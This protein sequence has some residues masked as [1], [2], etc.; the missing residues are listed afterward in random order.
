[1]V[2]KKS[3]F[4][5]YPER[6]GAINGVH[7]VRPQ[8]VA[9]VEFSNWTGDGRLRHPSFQG[10]RE[11]KAATEVTR[12]IAQATP[13]A[14]SKTTSRGSHSAKATA[15]AAATNSSGKVLIKGVELT[16]PDRVFYPD[17]GIT[18]RELAEYYV[19]CAER[20]L[21]HVAGRPLSIVRCPDGIGG[22]RFFQKHLGPYAPKAVRRVQIREKSGEGE[23]GVV[24]DT[25]GLVALAQI[26]ALEIHVWGSR[27]D[28]VER[29]DRLVFDLDPAPDVEWPRVIAA[30]QELR[31]FLRELKLESFVKTTGGKGLHLVVPIIR[32]Q[33][34]GPVYDFCRRIAV[35]VERAAPQRYI[36]TMSKKARTGKIFIDYQR[37]QRGATA[38]AA[39]S[40]RA[41]PG[42]PISRPISWS[43]LSRITSG[44]QFQLR[45]VL[46]RLAAERRDPWPGFAEMR[47]SISAQAMRLLGE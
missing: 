32:R 2:E 47:Q 45:G 23:Y 9:Q 14:P 25:A 35:A 19:A 15:S 17:E 13:N 38:V 46:K 1:L 30:A 34:W 16:H 44:D 12:E 22:Q 41:K 4:A 21:P 24:E 10:M 27:V 8:L 42:A 36:A 7:W 33:E 5:D 3:P 43:E 20:M 29:P 37:N 11:D 26:A 18:K 6:G 28:S 40:T 31:D 39:F